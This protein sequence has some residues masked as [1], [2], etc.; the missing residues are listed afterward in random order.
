M[1]SIVGIGFGPENQIEIENETIAPG[2]D[3]NIDEF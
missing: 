3:Q 1:G 2:A